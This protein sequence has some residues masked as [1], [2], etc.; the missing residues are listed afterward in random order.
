MRPDKQS[1]MRAA[2][3]DKQRQI[4]ATIERLRALGVGTVT[5][6]QTTAVLDR[7]TALVEQ[8]NVLLQALLDDRPP[9]E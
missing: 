6:Y 7:L 3:Q 4:L 2:Q 8:Q 9:Q 1:D 5:H